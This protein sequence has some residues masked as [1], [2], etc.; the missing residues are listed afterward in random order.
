MFDCVTAETKIYV[1]METMKFR[2]GRLGKKERG[3][4]R[5]PVIPGVNKG[6]RVERVGVERVSGGGRGTFVK[7]SKGGRA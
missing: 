6:W 7:I 4:G 5:K 1:Y 2:Y 3:G